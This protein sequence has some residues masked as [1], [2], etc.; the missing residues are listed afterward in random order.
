MSRYS[1]NN[2]VA[3]VVNWRLR[4][5]FSLTNLELSS[6]PKS[7]SCSLSYSLYVQYATSMVLT[8]SLIGVSSTSIVPGEWGNNRSGVFVWSLADVGR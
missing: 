4:F 3:S 1:Q 5:T 6:V 8:F 7:R 2:E